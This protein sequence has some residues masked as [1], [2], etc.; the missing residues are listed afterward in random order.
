MAWAFVPPTPNELTPARRGCAPRG[1]AC[2]QPLT[3]KGLCSKSI[4]GLGVVKCA[5][6]GMRSFASA[7]AVLMTPV[8]PAAIVRWPMLL[9][10]EPSEQKLVS[11]VKWRYACVSAATS[12]G[13]PSGVAVP[14]AS[15]YETLRASTPAERSASSTTAACPS[16]LG[17]VKLALTAPS[18][19]TATPRMT[20]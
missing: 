5:V 11:A 17:A 6:A 13:S 16:T 7:S 14:W 3:T 12:T 15:T 4:L 1:Q 20:A 9:L 10:T 19:L 18:L 2:V 8:A